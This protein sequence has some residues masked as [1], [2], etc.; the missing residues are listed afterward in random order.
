MTNPD[1]HRFVSTGYASVAHYQHRALRQHHPLN[2][3]RAAL[4]RH[5]HR[6]QLHRRPRLIPAAPRRPFNAPRLVAH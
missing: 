1:Q 6:A 4:D 3:E 5:A 2:A